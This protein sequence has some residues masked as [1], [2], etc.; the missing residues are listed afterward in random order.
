MYLAVCQYGSLVVV[1][2]EG[3]QCSPKIEP[4]FIGIKVLISNAHT[5]K[6]SLNP[7]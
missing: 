7:C 2:I 6:S 1:L 3:I 4:L 5:C